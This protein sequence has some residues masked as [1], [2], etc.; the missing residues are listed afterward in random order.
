[1]DTTDLIFYSANLAFIVSHLYG[2]LLKWYYRPKAYEE[3]FHD[4]FP[5][6]RS[7][8]TIYMLQILELPYL[9]QIGDAD[10]LFYA[11]AFALLV[12]SLQ[13]LVMCELYFFPQNPHPAKDY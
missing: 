4:L 6:Q 1:M 7:V 12:F 11:N 9:L 2:W 8:G 13:M 5:A 3:T 10:A